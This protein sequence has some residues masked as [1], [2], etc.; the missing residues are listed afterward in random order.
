MAGGPCLMSQRS[1]APLPEKLV[2]VELGVA[3]EEEGG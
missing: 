2:A 1:A 3:L